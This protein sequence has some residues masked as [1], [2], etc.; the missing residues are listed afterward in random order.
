LKRLR[1][2]PRHRGWNRAAGAVADR[3]EGLS[4]RRGDPPQGGRRH[5]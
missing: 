1:I 3:Q 2:K 5:I 4:G